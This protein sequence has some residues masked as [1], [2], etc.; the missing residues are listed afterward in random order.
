MGSVASLIWLG[1][2]TG[3]SEAIQNKGDE[4]LSE[5]SDYVKENKEYLSSEPNEENDNVTLELYQF[6]QESE[7]YPY[8]LN[9]TAATFL[10]EHEE[11]FPAKSIAELEGYID[12]GVEYKH[13]NKNIAKYGETL[14]YEESVVVSDIHEQDIGNDLWLTT[15]HVLD[16][17][18][19]SFVIFY[20]GELPDVFKED[21]VTVC[22]LP[23]GLS[24]FENVGGGSTIAVILA[25]SSVESNKNAFEEAVGDISVSEEAESLKIN[26]VVNES[27]EFMAETWYQNEGGIL[28]FGSLEPLDD[29][30]GWLDFGGRYVT[31]CDPE[32]CI[33]FTLKNEGEESLINPIVKFEFTDVVVKNVYEPFMP[34]NHVQGVGGYAGATLKLNDTL[35]PGTETP[36]F[37]LYLNEALF[38]NG[39]TG[40]V[41]ITLSADN[42]SAKTYEIPLMLK[43]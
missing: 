42:Y 40:T 28:A 22:G 6:L 5:A 12:K 31:Y 20:R 11:F 4:L 7:A 2:L 18:G 39:S 24:S 23:L 15:V 38:V 34:E 9:E 29:W 26:Y 1:G 41:A 37:V 14:F 36:V 21:T 3:C 10:D 30:A 25:G 33:N 43:N 27:D 35:Q 32:S 19:N 13:L 17:M 8:T 16:D